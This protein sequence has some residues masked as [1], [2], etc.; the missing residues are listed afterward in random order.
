[1]ILYVWT[2]G[3]VICSQSMTNRVEYKPFHEPWHAQ[4]F[5]LTV[6][7]NEQGHFDWK[8]WSEMFSD[9]LSS[10]GSKNFIIDDNDYYLIWL[11]TLEE[12]L[13]AK[14]KIGSGEITQYFQAWRKAF[15]NTPHGQPVSLT[16]LPAD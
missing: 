4:I 2:F 5:A 16:N 7:L 15:L 8:D 3:R 13:E 11:A 14:G 6:H 10:K 12:F 9:N 1:M